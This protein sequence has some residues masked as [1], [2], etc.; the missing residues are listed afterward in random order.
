MKPKERL[1]N[2]ATDLFY[3]QGYNATG[4]NQIL[5]KA[6]VAKASLYKHF[7]SKD[8]L[9]L[10]Y[11]QLSSNNWFANF[12]DYTKQFS[13]P[14]EI[15]INCF[16]FLESYSIQNKFN[17][18]RILN[19][20]TE[21]DNQNETIKSEVLAHKLKL[22]IF[23]TDLAY[24]LLQNKSKAKELGDIIYLA[25]EGATIESKVFKN[26]NSIKAA[27]KLVQKIIDLYN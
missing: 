8:D 16:T 14:K 3:I 7:T 2:S 18:C 5:E 26:A 6:Q 13:D 25:Y 20:L 24:Q 17:G 19:M 23:F 22:K 1:I 4:I 12:I 11:V 15:I 9:G 10:V 27:K 21:I